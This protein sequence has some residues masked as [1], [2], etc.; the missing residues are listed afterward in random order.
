MD[1]LLFYEYGPD[2]ATRRQP[3]RTEHLS[4]AWA[5][6]AAGHLVLAGAL[7]DP[8]DGAVLHFRVESP[9]LIEDFARGDPY[10]IHGLVTRW[11]IRPWT[12]V[13]GDAASQPVRP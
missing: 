10:V 6:Q 1:Y 4:R 9:A 13:V 11:Y 7:A 3:F 12:T 5:A 8:L 2:V